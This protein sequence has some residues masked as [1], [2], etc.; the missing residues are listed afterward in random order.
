MND[1]EK[2][3]FLQSEYRRDDRYWRNL[4]PT[5]DHFIKVYDTCKNRVIRQLSESLPIRV[6]VVEN[7]KSEEKIK[8]DIRQVEK[9]KTDITLKN[10]P[11]SM[12]K[13]VIVRDHGVCLCCKELVDV[14]KDNI[15]VIDEAVDLNLDNLQTVCPECSAY[16]VSS[17]INFLN[18][19]SP[20]VVQPAFIP[21]IKLPDE[22]CEFKRSLYRLVNLFYRCN[23]VCSVEY[24]ETGQSDL[25]KCKLC[26]KSEK[27]CQLKENKGRNCRLWGIELFSGN[28]PLWLQSF[29]D[30]LLKLI[31]DALLANKY[32]RL[33][34]LLIK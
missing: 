4:Y 15:V 5:F 33:F 8:T 27:I 14:K 18:N 17:G 16:P 21:D 6:S 12:V 25:A 22:F 28:N 11:S 9:K 30:E 3:G 7:S 1:I 23:A 19:K 20:L 13:Q 24:R 32:Q 31:N 29:H 2:S 10:L 34:R 26:S